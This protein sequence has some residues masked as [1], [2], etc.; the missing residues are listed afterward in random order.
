MDKTYTT[1][2]ISPLGDK[3]PKYG[4]TYYGT[5]EEAQMPVMFNLMNPVDFEEGMPFTSEEYTVK[6]SKAGKDYMRLKK[7]KVLT[8][9]KP[10]ATV[11]PVKDTLLEQI[12]NNTQEILAILKAETKVADRVIEDIGDEPVNL[13]DIPF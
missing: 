1:I 13:D 7:V 2:K 11:A 4:Q 5:V 9:A 12:F 8:G 6:T 10:L 3:D